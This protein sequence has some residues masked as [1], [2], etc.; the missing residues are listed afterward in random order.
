MGGCRVM[1]SRAGLRNLLVVF[2]YVLGVTIVNMVMVFV[3]RDRRTLYDLVAGTV[4]VDVEN[5]LP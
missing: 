2:D 4:L 5:R 1:A 3:R